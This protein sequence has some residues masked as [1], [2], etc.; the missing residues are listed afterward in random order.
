[1]SGELDLD[2]PGPEPE[3]QRSERSQRRDRA[4]ERD[5]RGDLGNRLGA[6]FERLAQSVEGRGDDELAAMIR[7]DKAAMVGGLV[8]LTSR[9][10]AL[11]PGVLAALAI[12]EPLIAFG[13]I[14]RLLL[15][16]AAWRRE[17]AAQA[18][19]GW[20][21]EPEPEGGVQVPQAFDGPAEPEEEFVARPWDL[22]K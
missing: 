10:P 4:R 8:S 16:R 19:D 17:E 3:P 14:F 1:V 6:I 18:R 15:R 2:N 13:R 9:A 22:S 7:E 12:V 20:E 21:Y 5:R 11:A